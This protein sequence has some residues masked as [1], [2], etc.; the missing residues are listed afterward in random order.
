M[1]DLILDTIFFDNTFC[2]ISIIKGATSLV[3]KKLLSKYF[4]HLLTLNWEKRKYRTWTIE[5]LLTK[6]ISLISIIL[7]VL[8]LG[9]V[10]Y[11]FLHFLI[12]KQIVTLEVK[13]LSPKSFH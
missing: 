12:L 11:N 10:N 6:P 8:K 4:S 1:T 5:I 7:S 2:N 3:F 13:V 9:E